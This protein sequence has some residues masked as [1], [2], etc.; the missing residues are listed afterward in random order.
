MEDR[1]RVRKF[2][3]KPISH[4]ILNI[5][6]CVF[7]PIF[8][9]LFR[10]KNIGKKVFFMSFRV[11]ISMT[12]LTLLRLHSTYTAWFFA[13]HTKII[14][15]LERMSK[16][17]CHHN[18]RRSRPPSFVVDVVVDKKKRLIALCV[19]VQVLICAFFH[20]FFSAFLFFH[21]PAMLLVCTLNRILYI[22]H[23]DIANDTK[24]TK[25]SNS[26]YTAKYTTTIKKY[27][28][29]KLEKEKTQQHHFHFSHCSYEHGVV[30]MWKMCDITE[31]KY[32][33]PKNGDKIKKNTSRMKT[34][35]IIRTYIVQHL[36]CTLYC[37]QYTYN[38]LAALN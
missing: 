31:T 15:V 18:H 16:R 36:V 11:Y 2:S 6:L 23:S 20:T 1:E 35:R 25:Q 12:T 8:L 5:R 37:K 19:Y 21:S 29:K 3:Q 24:H 17:K 34:T 13:V 33:Y 26:T 14:P 9:R 32:M 38:I 30:C 28:K 4:S 10:K 27:E 7:H 22:A